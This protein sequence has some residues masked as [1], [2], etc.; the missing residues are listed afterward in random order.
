MPWLA[1]NFFAAIQAE[2]VGQDIIAADNGTTYPNSNSGVFRTY[3][4]AGIVAN[5]RQRVFIPI[6]VAVPVYQ[7]CNG[8]QVKVNWRV[9]A[10]VGILL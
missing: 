6:S 9:N 10:G 5:L 3:L 8:Y 4:A 7:T 1:L 2:H